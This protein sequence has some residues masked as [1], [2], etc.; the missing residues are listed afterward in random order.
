[1]PMIGHEIVT[2]N[3]G[4]VFQQRF[5]QNALECLLALK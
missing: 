5:A 4:R 1:M 3:A 2:E